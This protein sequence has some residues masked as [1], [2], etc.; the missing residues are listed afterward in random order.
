MKN[1]RAIDYFL[2][3]YGIVSIAILHPIAYYYGGFLNLFRIGF[4]EGTSYGFLFFLATG[5][6]ATILGAYGVIATAFR[7]EMQ[8]RSERHWVKVI[9]WTARTIS[10]LYVL[11]TFSIFTAHQ[12]IRYYPRTEP[13]PIVPLV[14]GVLMLIGLGLAW[15]WEFPGAL[16]SL[17][18][19]IGIC[20]VNAH[21]LR[22]S[23]LY[24]VPTTAILFLV[25]WWS[26][27]SPDQPK[28]M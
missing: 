23:T 13:L 21:A 26:S 5:S 4:P 6:V 15:K 12:I 22:E 11:L 7:K 2:L 18:A 19:F 20:I 9:R 28:D 3:T 27:R 25:S 17:V 14:L 1:N 10:L 16:I 24:I 8:E